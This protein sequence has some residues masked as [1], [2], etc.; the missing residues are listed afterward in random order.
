MAKHLVMPVQ[1]AGTSASMV[2]DA[3]IAFVSTAPPKKCPRSR[4]GHA[5]LPPGWDNKWCPGCVDYHREASMKGRAD[6]R[7]NEGG[8]RDQIKTAT[9]AVAPK[10]SGAS[11][12]YFCSVPILIPPGHSSGPL[13][14]ESCFKRAIAA[15]EKHALQ[16]AQQ[17]SVPPVPVR[18]PVPAPMYRPPPALPQ[19]P[20]L[21]P[22]YT[23]LN[24]AGPSSLVVPSQA[25]PSY[26][27]F[28]GHARLRPRVS[29]TPPAPQAAEVWE[30]TPT[31]ITLPTSFDGRPGSGDQNPAEVVSQQPPATEEKSADPPNESKTSSGGSDGDLNLETPDVIDDLELEYPDD[32]SAE[33]SPVDEHADSSGLQIVAGEDH[34]MTDAPSN[35]EGS[36]SSDPQSIFDVPDGWD[37]EVSDLTDLTD[38]GESEVEP[39]RP[40]NQKT[41]LKIRIRI[42]PGFRLPKP[43]VCAIKTCNQVLET[44]YRWKLCEPC[45]TRCREYTRKRL[46][47][48]NPRKDLDAQ[49]HP[50]LVRA[51]VLPHAQSQ[52]HFMPD[53]AV[54][55]H[56]GADEP[57]PDGARA[58]TVR[59]CRKLLPP[60][61][62][63]KYKMC[64]RCRQR[65]RF[66]KNRRYAM[67]LL[68]EK[69]DENGVKKNGG[70]SRHIIATFERQQAKR[71]AEGF[72]ALER[73]E[74]VKEEGVATGKGKGKEK[75][76]DPAVDE[77]V[78]PSIEEGLV[79]MD[80][81]PPS[82]SEP[83]KP[84]LNPVS[85]RPR[86]AYQDIITL[87]YTLRSYLTSFLNALT[88]HTRLKLLKQMQAPASPPPLPAE[89]ILFVFE[90]ECSSI[91][92][93]SD[94]PESNSSVLRALAAAQRL[95]E[96]LRMTFKVLGSPGMDGDE[97]VVRL[98]CMQ[99]FALP[100]GRGERPPAPRVPEGWKPSVGSS[101]DVAKPLEAAESSNAALESSA[102][103]AAPAEPSTTPNESADVP[104]APSE[105]PNK[106]SEEP[107][108]PSES[109]S[110]SS[111][112]PVESKV[113]TEL[114][115]APA[116]SSKPPVE[117]GDAPA[118]PEQKPQS[119]VQ[120]TPQE[121]AL[122]EQKQQVMP[123]VILRNMAGEL[124]LRISDDVSPD[125]PLRGLRTIVRFRLVG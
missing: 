118:A 20:T 27:P 82:P 39:E 32:D 75:A 71:R 107:I 47:V 6:K 94:S 50:D 115:E 70:L 69:P 102:T 125:T 5:L 43:R 10:T 96:M 30:V 72:Q 52:F 37:S 66:N 119:E 4:C 123:S 83:P 65:S 81:D 25:R 122:P 54:H 99:T 85:K 24:L 120:P 116:E 97:M 40:S 110:E 106:S 45:R 22:S 15:K 53:A 124:E 11:R 33:P 7:G 91:A 19:V 80:V 17:P 67:A 87:F 74:A 36:T 88:E 95:E 8:M 1:P 117:P 57:L 55:R 56:A 51:G 12:C 3:E 16:Q 48:Q 61:A 112:I 64:N 100:V 121:E 18:A 14:C 92:G 29:E 41:G 86:P 44:G 98:R 89:P 59:S 60:L 34:P 26:P 101:E 68:L 78:K 104:N 90:G 77:D 35:P 21:P 13:V 42:P 49:A 9:P 108:K 114:S 62:Q 111:N 109:L 93:P 38:S 28:G 46:N 76:V 113:S 103:T 105:V 73:E 23:R 63:H 84:A 58:C 79:P 31:R 2:G